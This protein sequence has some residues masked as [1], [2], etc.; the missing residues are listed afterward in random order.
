MHT[1]GEHGFI[2]VCIAVAL[3]FALPA[4][5][6]NLITN[7]GF[8]AANS[9]IGGFVSACSQ[10]TPT[11]GCPY[12]PGWTVQILSGN[13]QLDCLVPGST[14]GADVISPP[15][16]IC[17]PGNPPSTQVSATS[18]HG[19]GFLFTLWKAPGYSPDGGNYFMIDGGTPFS[20][21]LTQSVTGLH[22]GSIYTLG[23]WEAAGQEDCLYDDGVNCDPSPSGTNLTQ[24]FQVTFGSTTLTGPTMSEP[25]HT[26]VAWNH[27]NMTFVA[28]AV[29]QTLTFYARGTPDIGPPLLFV[30]GVTLNEAPEA[31]SSELL[32]L[33][34]AAGA[35]ARAAVLRRR[36][37]K[38]LEAPPS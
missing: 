24:W 30:D 36:K 26:S 21:T 38:T 35:L 15:D 9:Q 31:S 37:R 34:I 11:S 5:A 7:P 33:G 6:S 23:F 12:L 20:G 14:R 28:T 1:R 13:G 3:L 2:P 22:I 16:A 25:P 32:G 19:A 10:T 8:D 18:Q 4:C 29:T 17:T 27:V